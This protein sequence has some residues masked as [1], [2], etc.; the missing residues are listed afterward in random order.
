[1][2]VFETKH[3]KAIELLPSKRL[4]FFL[5]CGTIIDTGVIGYDAGTLVCVDGEA[6][7]RNC[8]KKNCP[9]KTC[10]VEVRNDTD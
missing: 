8:N 3:V 2:Y 9:I 1:M 5:N 4:R 10:L 6:P 7:L